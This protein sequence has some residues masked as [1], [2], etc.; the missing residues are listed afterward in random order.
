MVATYSLPSSTVRT[1]RSCITRCDSCTAG[2]RVTNALAVGGGASR[3][4]FGSN[5]RTRPP[6]LRRAAIG[7]PPRSPST[8]RRCARCSAPATS[9]WRP[10]ARCS[11]SPAATVSTRVASPTDLDSAARSRVW[12]SIPPTSPRRG[13]R[14]RTR[15][16]TPRWRS[17]PPR[18]IDCHLPTV[19]STSCGAR[20]VSAASPSRSP[21]WDT[22][23][24]CFGLAAS[25]PG[26]RSA[27]PVR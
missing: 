19:R 10:A 14:R 26:R 3:P 8:K 17:W 20:R 6:R 23:L 16:A 7:L 15:R 18:S 12:T 4:R 13:E 1:S 11:T 5:E 21:C 9:W 22:W 25:S 2:S 27:S 24:G